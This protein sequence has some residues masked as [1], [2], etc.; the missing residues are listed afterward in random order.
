MRI[1]GN[2]AS[3][4]TPTPADLDY[5]RSL[6]ADPDTMKDAGGSIDLDEGRA[7]RWYQKMV[8]PG[9]D[10]DRYFLIVD[11]DSDEPVGEV[12]FHRYDPK[13]KAAEL[14]IKIEAG[15]RY[16][17]H[18]PEALRLLL[19]YFFGAFGGEVMLDP[20]APGNRNGQRALSRFGFERDRSRKDVFLLRMTKQRFRSMCSGHLSANRE[21]ENA[22][23]N[24]VKKATKE[25]K[26]SRMKTAIIAL[27]L[28]AATLPAQPGFDEAKPYWDNRGDR[29]ELQKAIEI[30]AKFYETAPSYELAERLAYA[31]YFLA[32]AFEQGDQKSKD[33]YTGYEWGIKALCFDPGFKQRFVDQKQGMGDA[34]KGVPREFSGGIFWTATCIGKWGKMRNIF[35]TLKTS[36][37][38]RK[39]VEY[40]YTIDKT[41]YYGGPARWLGAYFAIAPGIAGG[42]MEKSKKFYAEA[43]AIAPGYFATKVLMAENYYSKLKDRPNYDK[44]LDEVLAGDA[45]AIPEMAIEQAVE[46][47]KARKLKTEKID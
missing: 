6:W 16:Q 33:Y 27:V 44:M 38:A 36:K 42:D 41:Y 39:L 47:G 23:A 14:N 29:A 5:I 21:W 22:K 28:C 7:R 18:G 9:S 35:K 13:T 24:R 20:V 46:Q 25:K 3:L 40:L 34:I 31:Y 19:D 1:E 10:T 37:Q 8:D 32:D 11:S 2:I 15:R 12:S 26:G 4:R 43:L 45:A 17:G 30:Y